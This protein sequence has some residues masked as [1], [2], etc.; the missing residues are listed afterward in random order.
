MTDRIVLSPTPPEW[1]AL[2]SIAAKNAWQLTHP[3]PSESP[4]ACE[5]VWC[6]R[7]QQ[8]TIRK[9]WHPV[10]RTTSYQVDVGWD[11]YEQSY[12]GSDGLGEIMKA[13]LHAFDVFR[14]RLPMTVDD[15]APGD[16]YLYTLDATDPRL[17]SWECARED[18]L[19]SSPDGGVIYEFRQSD[20]RDIDIE[21]LLDDVWE[22]VQEWAKEADNGAFM[23]F[24][25]LDGT[26]V[27][28]P[29][30]N[31]L[32]RHALLYC[33]GAAVRNCAD[34]SDAAWT[35][36]GRMFRVAEDGYRRLDGRDE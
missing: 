36:T 13:A 9:R 18:L 21:M 14:A 3:A 19:E 5:V 7:W 20:A 4:A 6:A 30:D 33:F 2:E 1:K 17:R 16:P 15:D 23:P 25:H 32:I 34:M 8:W 22:M 31:A 29:L 12:V 24:G 35:P 28:G 26:A 10:D 11:G 27:I